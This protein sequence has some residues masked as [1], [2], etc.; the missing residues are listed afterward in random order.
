MAAIISQEDLTIEHRVKSHGHQGSPRPSIPKSS[1][2]SC[3]LKPGQKPSIARSKQIRGTPSGKSPIGGSTGSSPN[4]K[5]AD[6]EV[7][8]LGSLAMDI[9]K[10]I[11]DSISASMCS[12]ISQ[13]TQDMIAALKDPP[14]DMGGQDQQSPAD[15]GDKQED[16]PAFQAEVIQ[17]GP[18]SEMPDEKRPSDG[19]ASKNVGKAKDSSATRGNKRE[20]PTVGSELANKKR[21]VTDVES[22]QELLM[23]T[24]M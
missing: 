6:L 21:K 7:V 16:V 8:D 20:S 12:S 14:P 2:C 9:G 23:W 4:P 24:Q 17:P 15:K 3:R 10:A 18:S 5:P 22:E 11:G 19:C 1:R 13:F